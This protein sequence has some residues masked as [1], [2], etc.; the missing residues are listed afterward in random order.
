MTSELLEDILNSISSTIADSVTEYQYDDVMTN[1]REDI[2]EVLNA[3]FAGFVEPSSPKPQTPEKKSKKTKSKKS[4]R[5]PKTKSVK[6]SSDAPFTMRVLNSI[7]KTH[8]IDWKSAKYFLVYASADP[9]TREYPVFEIG[10]E[11]EDEDISRGFIYK[12]YDVMYKKDKIFKYDKDYLLG[13]NV[14]DLFHPNVLKEM[15]ELNIRIIYR[16][17]GVENVEIKENT[18]IPIEDNVNLDL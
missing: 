17:N 14:L 16:K 7:G 15:K 9:I 5:G 10:P 3:Y 2:G 6:S 12:L 13:K 11:F 18:K 4:K 1:L 8:N